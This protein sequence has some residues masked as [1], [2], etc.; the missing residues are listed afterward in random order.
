MNPINYIKLAYKR[1]GDFKGRSLRSEYWYYIICYYVV[2][3]SS[4]I[5][6]YYNE[7]LIIITMIWGLA[8]FITVFSLVVR[9]LHDLNLS[10][11]FLVV[12]G[13]VGAIGGSLESRPVILLAFFGMKVLFM[14]PGTKGRNEYGDQV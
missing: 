6:L 13:I 11:W 12:P 1:T 4:L 3:I 5:G 2:Y 14:F 7:G 8:N 9:R 10:G